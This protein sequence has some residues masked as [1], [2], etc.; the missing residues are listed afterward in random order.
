MYDLDNIPKDTM[1]RWH[2]PVVPASRE[3]V[4]EDGMRPGSDAGP[5]STSENPCTH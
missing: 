4:V 2:T 3:A 1:A 5:G